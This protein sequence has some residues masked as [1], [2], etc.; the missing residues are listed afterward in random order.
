M[1]LAVSVLI[2]FSTFTILSG[3]TT[4]NMWSNHRQR[5]MFAIISSAMCCKRYYYYDEDNNDVNDDFSDI[6]RVL[7][8]E[9]QLSSL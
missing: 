7:S 9:I 6:I 1:P 4:I 8:E 5:L 3:L 2:V